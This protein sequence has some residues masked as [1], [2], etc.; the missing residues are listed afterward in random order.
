MLAAL[1][2]ARSF[3]LARRFGVVRTLMAGTALQVVLIS[4]MA[5]TVSPWIAVLLLLRSCHP[6]IS[7][8]VINAEV[9]PRL[10]Q[11]LRATYLSLMSLAGRLGYALLL[12][13]LSA[14]VGPQGPNDAASL[15]EILRWTAGLAGLGWLVLSVSGQGIALRR[16]SPGTPGRA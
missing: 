8:V 11:S 14:I 2:A 1:A 9:T 3:G 12:L 15:S 10:S 4:C 16:G 5:W 7:Q 13:G 6:A